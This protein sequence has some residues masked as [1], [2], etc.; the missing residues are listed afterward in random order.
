[1]PIRYERDEHRRR[2]VIEI[3]GRFDFTELQSCL[4][5]H[6]A[7]SGWGYGLLYDLRYLNVPADLETPREFAG[8]MTE[9]YGPVQRGPVAVL[10]SESKMYAWAC[11]YAAKVKAQVTIAVFRDHDEADAWLSGQVKSQ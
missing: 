7:E 4:E 8:T 5:R 6:R 2:A 11:A 3:A 1:M 9:L 10:A